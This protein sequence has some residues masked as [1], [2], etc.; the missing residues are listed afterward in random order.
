MSNYEIAK[1]AVENFEFDNMMPPQ[2]KFYYDEVISIVKEALR[3]KDLQI[4]TII[5]N[6]L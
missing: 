5:E 4:N 1:L 6:C 3:I 2:T